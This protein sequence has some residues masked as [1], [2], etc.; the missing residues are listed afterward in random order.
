MPHCHPTLLPKGN[1][2]GCWVP[3][4]G[5]EVPGTWEEG[6]SVQRGHSDFLSVFSVPCLPWCPVSP[7]SK[8]FCFSYT[9]D[10]SRLL[11]RWLVD[12]VGS[13]WG[14]GRIQYLLC[15]SLPHAC[16]LQYLVPGL[17]SF[18]RALQSILPRFLSACCRRS[19][20]IILHPSRSLLPPHLVSDCHDCLANPQQCCCF[21]L[22]CFFSLILRSL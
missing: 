20:V 17:G 5:G 2:L 7:T 11:M 4:S 15:L 9:R 8:L 21:A 6:A 19:L 3:G 1:K 10:L 14:S 12:H 22:V 13:S 18:A 16:P